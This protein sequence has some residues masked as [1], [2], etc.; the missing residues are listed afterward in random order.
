MNLKKIVIGA[1]ALLVMASCGKKFTNPFG[2]GDDKPQVYE[3]TVLAEQSA[4]LETVY[5]ATIKGQEDIEI[6]PRIDGFIDAIRVDEG[7]VVR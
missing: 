2:D 5:P 4:Q 6:R 7:S 3:T 1:M